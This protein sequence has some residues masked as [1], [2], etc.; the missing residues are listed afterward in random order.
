M[1][2][3]PP[4][5]EPMVQLSLP[6]SHPWEKVGADLFQ[7]KESTYMVVVDYY[8]RYMEIQ[9]LISTTSAG[10]ISAH[11]LKVLF[12]RHSI[13]VEFMDIG[14]QFASQEMKEFAERYY[15]FT[16]RTSSPHYPQSN[17]LAERTVKTVKKL[18]SN[19]N[20][21]YLAL[22]SYRAMPLPYYDQRLI[23]TARKLQSSYQ[24][25][26]QCGSP[27]KA[28][29]LLELCRNSWNHPDPMQ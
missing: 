20:Y 29:S 5:V 14:P 17:G 8:S 1:K 4:P 11:V 6:I 26:R 15:C 2:N 19:T 21:P 24:K 18:I 9:K 25:V 12:S 10:V 3:T 13:P 16:L 28:A 23:C 27:F 7:L 22:L